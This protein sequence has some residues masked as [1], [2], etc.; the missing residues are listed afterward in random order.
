MIAEDQ[1]L[2]FKGRPEEK[3][4]L[5]EIVSNKRN[6]VDVDKF[7]YLSRDSLYLGIKN[8]FDFHRFLQFARVCEVDGRKTICTRD[9]EEDN[10]YDLFYIRHRLHKRAYQHRVNK[11]IEHMIAEAFLKAD[12]HIQIEG[13]GGRMFTL[14]T[15]NE[16][17]EAYT[18]LTDNVFEEI[19]KSSHPELQEAREIL[20]NIISRKIHKFVGER[21]VPIEDWKSQITGWKEKLAQPL[22]DEE[23]NN[24]KPEDFE[25]L[26]INMDYGMKDKNPVE[27][28]H[29]YSKKE[30]DV[31]KLMSPENVRTNY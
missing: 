23:E 26:V 30:P 17:M 27:H 22:P 18:K 16:D 11:V 20:Q 3:S 28:M 29:F 24:L 12:G 21:K 31:A 15:A 25:I 10:M 2:D 19:L 8:T 6:G 7:D 9:I 13:S 14:S 4:F 5:Y 1:K